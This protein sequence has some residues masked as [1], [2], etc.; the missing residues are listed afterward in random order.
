MEPLGDILK[1]I[2]ANSQKRQQEL[3]QLEIDAINAEPPAESQIDV[4]SYGGYCSG[5][6]WVSHRVPLGHP[7]FGQAFP[8]P[9]C[10]GESDVNAVLIERFSEDFPHK[11]EPRTWKNFEKNNSFRVDLFNQ[12]TGWMNDEHRPHLL[13]L[14]GPH[15]TGKS[16]ALEAMAREFSARG[17]PTQYHNMGKLMV[18]FRTE[19]GKKPSNFDQHYNYLKQPE[20]LVVD[21]ITEWG[22]QFSS[23]VLVEILEPR[24]MGR[25][26]MAVATNLTMTRLAEI[27]G[28]RLADRIFDIDS[29]DTELVYTHGPSYRSGNTWSYQTAKGRR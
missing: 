6:G 12:V 21:D 1:R 20:L 7:D 9:E 15:G 13:S 22:T 3:T 5:S 16:H 2:K 10:V 23:E 25:G 17:I 14:A 4:C 29:G 19:A 27:W 8:C 26:L 28:Y 24:Y 11:N 18:T